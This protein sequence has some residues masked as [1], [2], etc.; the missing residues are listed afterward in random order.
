M[1]LNRSELVVALHSLL[2]LSERV[3]S[4]LHFTKLGGGGGG[5][6]WL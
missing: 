1:R 5:L 2:L 6:Y 3:L 4:L